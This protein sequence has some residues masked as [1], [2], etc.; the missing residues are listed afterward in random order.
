[1]TLTLHNDRYFNH[2]TFIKNHYTT[3][4]NRLGLSYVH[5]RYTSVFR[6]SQRVSAPRAT[7]LCYKL[8]SLFNIPSYSLNNYLIV[9]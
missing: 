3:I 1:M 8:I 6:R 4:K 5:H 2:H 9:A 7:L